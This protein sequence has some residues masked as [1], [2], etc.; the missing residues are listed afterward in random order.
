[1]L[2]VVKWLERER[3]RERWRWNGRQSRGSRKR[4][5][6][7]GEGERVER[8]IEARLFEHE[9]HYPDRLHDVEFYWGADVWNVTYNDS[10]LYIRN[11]ASDIY[12]PRI[13]GL[14]FYRWRSVTITYFIAATPIMVVGMNSFGHWHLL[15][16]FIGRGEVYAFRENCFVTLLW[17]G[18]NMLEIA[19]SSV[20][21]YTVW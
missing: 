9:R 16:S 18:K 14:W 8:R 6:G 20:R 5:W 12:D 11:V 19:R 2:T 7:E 17:N 10:T 13:Y 3:R 4:G 15:A 21:D 1:M